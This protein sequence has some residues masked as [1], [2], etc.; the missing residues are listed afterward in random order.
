[1]QFAVFIFSRARQ[2]I[3]IGSPLGAEGTES[4]PAGSLGG[5]TDHSTSRPAHDLSLTGIAG[6]IYC[7]TYILIFMPTQTVTRSA[8]S[9]LEPGKLYNVLAEAGNIPKWAPD[10]AFSRK[11]T[12]PRCD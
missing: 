4:N 7:R 2:A 6:Y 3:E 1:M 5:V 8:E 11:S 10:R 9:D 12:V